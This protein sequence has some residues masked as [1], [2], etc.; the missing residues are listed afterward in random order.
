MPDGTSAAELLEW[1][2]NALSDGDGL[3]P[4]VW[5]HAAALLARRSLERALDE[6]WRTRAPGLEARP[7][8]YQ[9]LCLPAYVD[10]DL[11]GR[12]S[13]VWWSLNNASR[14]H[15]YELAPTASELRGWLATVTEVVD[16]LNVTG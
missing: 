9:L 1:A 10:A 3:P 4:G 2:D 5:Q 6:M 15:P 12:T 11:A 8:R 14:H 7:A 16:A 13:H